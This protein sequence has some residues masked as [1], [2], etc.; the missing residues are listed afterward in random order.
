MFGGGRKFGDHSSYLEDIR[1]YC[2]PNWEGRST[3]VF[4]GTTPNFHTA[5]SKEIDV[6]YFMKQ[7]LNLAVRNCAQQKKKDK[8]KDRPCFHTV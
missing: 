5:P 3:V 1:N 8:I 2:A 4:A 7:A 6:T